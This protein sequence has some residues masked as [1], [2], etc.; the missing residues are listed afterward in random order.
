MTKLESAKELIRAK[1]DCTIVAGLTC[2]DC[3]NYPS[4]LKLTRS[5]GAC[6]SVA[7]KYKKDHEKDVE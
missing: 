1:G 7:I 6:L 5:K 4:C 3:C 2:K